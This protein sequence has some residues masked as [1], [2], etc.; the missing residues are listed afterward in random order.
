MFEECTALE[1]EKSLS[2][3]GTTRTCDNVPLVHPPTCKEDAECNDPNKSCALVMLGERYAVMKERTSGNKRGQ[4]YL[5]RD[6]TNDETFE[7]CTPNEQ[8]DI[9]NICGLYKSQHID[10][11]GNDQDAIVLCGTAK[12]IL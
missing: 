4:K 1:F 10:I 11:K 12:Y 6:M 9:G 2:V 8:C 3:C 5:S 7:Q